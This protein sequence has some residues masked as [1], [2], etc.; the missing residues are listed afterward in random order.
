MTGYLLD[1]H[2]VIWWWMDHPRL[3]TTAREIIEAD[4]HRLCLSVASVWEVAIK[5]QAGRLPELPAFREEYPALMKASRFELLTV[6]DGDALTA[7]YLGSSHRDPFDR[8]VAAQ[9]IDRNLVVLTRD[10]E[11]AGLGCETLW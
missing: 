4:G 11:F 9:A 7:A 10:G 3:S 8:L 1:T 6:T 2:A 5:S